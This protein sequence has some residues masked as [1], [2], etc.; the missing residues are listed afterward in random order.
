MPRPRDL[1]AYAVLLGVTRAMGVNRGA[2]AEPQDRKTPPGMVAIPGGECTMG[3][4]GG[5][6]PAQCG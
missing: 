2:I 5:L 6:V 4:S 1:V 3:S